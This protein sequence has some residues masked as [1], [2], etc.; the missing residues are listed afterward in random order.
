MNYVVIQTSAQW[1]QHD[2]PAVKIL[3]HLDVNHCTAL[4]Q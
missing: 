3:L 2:S 4:M 1:D